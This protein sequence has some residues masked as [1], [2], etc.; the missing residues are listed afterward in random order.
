M[1]IYVDDAGIRAEQDLH[2]RH[3]AVRPTHL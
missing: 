3:L 1:T 2:H